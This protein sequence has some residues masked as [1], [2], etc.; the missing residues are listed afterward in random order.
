MSLS[1]VPF[2]PAQVSSTTNAVPGGQRSAG[3]FLAER[4]QTEV[5]HFGIRRLPKIHFLRRLDEAGRQNS[6]E[7][8]TDKFLARQSHQP[9]AVT[10]GAAFVGEGER[11]GGGAPERGAS[12]TGRLNLEHSAKTSV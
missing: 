10:I 12:G 11:V 1:D 7:E 9:R 4:L 6:E 5:A 8:P 3:P 2:A